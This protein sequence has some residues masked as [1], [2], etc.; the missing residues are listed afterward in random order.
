[1]MFLLGIFSLW[2]FSCDEDCEYSADYDDDDDY[3]NSYVHD[4]CV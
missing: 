2:V 3:C 4:R 1:M